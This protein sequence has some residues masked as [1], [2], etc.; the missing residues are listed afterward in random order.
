MFKEYMQD[1]ITHRSGKLRVPD[2]Q[3][4]QYTFWID[5]EAWNEAWDNGYIDSE[6]NVTSKFREEYDMMFDKIGKMK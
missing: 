4:Y 5:K 3:P 1:I 2:L 6:G